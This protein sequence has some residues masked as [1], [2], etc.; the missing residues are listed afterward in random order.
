[1]PGQAVRC[2]PFQIW[3][4]KL[5][6]NRYVP[7]IYLVRTRYVPGIYLARIPV[8]SCTALPVWVDGYE[9]SIR[10]L[11][12]RELRFDIDLILILVLVS[13][14]VSGVEMAG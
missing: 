12:K 3:N 5:A 1:M 10:R 4:F 6:C 2:P 11:A 9:A 13:A 14:A 7:G 8:S